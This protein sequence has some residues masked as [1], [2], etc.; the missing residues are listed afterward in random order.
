MAKPVLVLHLT[1]EL[2][3][4]AECARELRTRLQPDQ[5]MILRQLAAEVTAEGESAA[6]GER[7]LVVPARPGELE[8]AVKSLRLQVAGRE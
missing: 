8:A 4:A 1:L 2:D 3:R 5:W 6:T 7:V